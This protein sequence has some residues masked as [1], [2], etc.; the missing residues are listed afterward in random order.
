MKKLELKHLAPYL[1]YGLKSIDDCGNIM[2]IDWQ[3]QSYTNSIVG[4]CHV[5]KTVN[6]HANSFT[7]ILHPLSDITKEIEVDG[8]KFVPL[9]KLY[10][11]S[12]IQVV[13]VVLDYKIEIIGEEDGCFG[14]VVIDED[15]KRDGF[16]LNTDSNKLQ[17]QITFDKKN[18][19]G[20]WYLNQLELINKLFEWHFDVFGLIDAGLAIDINTLNK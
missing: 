5:L 14:L 10:E 7:P 2:V 16:S 13:D 9:V 15:G 19:R 18:N 11:L 8:E 17:F 4:L 6:S 12:C 3:H 1:P 20:S